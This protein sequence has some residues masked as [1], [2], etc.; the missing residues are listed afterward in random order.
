[1]VFPSALALFATLICR[2]ALVEREL[3]E[4]KAMLTANRTESLNEE[5]I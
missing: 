2:L 1:M 5:E 3:A 4:I